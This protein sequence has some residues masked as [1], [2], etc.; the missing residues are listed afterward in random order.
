M[1]GVTLSI[2]DA[3]GKSVLTNSTVPANGAYGPITLTG[4]GPF[5][6]VAC[7]NA[8]DKYTCLYSVTQ[9]GGTADITPLSSAVVLLA[10][11]AVPTS[12]MSGA[13]QGL[14]AT[15]V[16][17][18]QAQ[19][20][21]AIGPALADAG[22]NSTTDLITSTLTA[23]SRSGYDRLLDDLGVTLGQD[24]TP[25]IEMD[26]RLG[27][28]AL[29]VSAAGTSGQIAIDPGASAL[30]L[31][32]IETLFASMT[33]A[34]ATTGACDA[35]MPALV[36]PNAHMTVGGVNFTGAGVATGVCGQMGIL[37]DG[38]FTFGTKLLSPQLG[39]C[40]FSGVSG[41][42]AVC[43]VSMIGQTAKGT[44]I[45]YALNQ[46]VA[47]QG[48]N[49]LFLGDMQPFPASA[50]ARAQRLRRV[51]GTQ[52]D[53]YLRAI[54]VSISVASGAQCASVS[55]KD[56]NG[57]DS[58]M[59]YYKPVSGATNLSL[60]MV[61]SVT[62]QVSLDPTTGATRGL[63]DRWIPLPS[64]SA[65]DAMVRNFNAS[66]HAV[67]VS[68]FSDGLCTTPLTPSG[69][70]AVFSLDLPGVP[71]LTAALPGLPWPALATAS[72]TTLTSMKGAAA[73]KIS[74]SPSWTFASTLLG[75]STAQLCT[76][77]LCN[78][79]SIIG[80]LAVTPSAL[81]AAISATVGSTAIAATDFKQLRLIGRNGDGVQLNADF[82]SCSTVTSGTACAVST[83][84]R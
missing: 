37:S 23:G 49:W 76:D 81:T 20:Q 51:D 12:P 8:A 15:A 68:L 10:S 41:S 69:G 55:Q 25:F 38:T 40:D 13:V 39:H 44:L 29:N 67:K 33:A 42:S 30:N 45:P 9:S 6:L 58:L 82:Q 64:G 1:N 74:Y 18:A 22:L 80:S 54:G 16:A 83:P 46:A 57:N 72:A 53:S 2:L 36:A 84:L 28:G 21:A 31:S 59:A 5:R 60:W 17:A 62:N 4:T 78:T 34:M 7:G 79:K 63:D 35:G 48:S 32:G 19:L 26:V 70:A 52:V 43:K 27:T 65:G 56:L 61:D 3:T 73:G 71:A 77:S 47:W 11:G 24:T 50:D 14:S 66:G 75:M